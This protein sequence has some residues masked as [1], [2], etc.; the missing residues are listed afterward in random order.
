M[1]LLFKDLFNKDEITSYFK[2]IIELPT[3]K[4][5][6]PQ[7]LVLFLKKYFNFSDRE[8]LALNYDKF[9]KTLIDK[10]KSMDQLLTLTRLTNNDEDEFKYDLIKFFDQL[11]NEQIFKPQ[12]SGLKNLNST[13]F[14]FRNII[15]G[16]LVDDFQPVQ[17]QQ[18][19]INPE[20]YKEI[21]EIFLVNFDNFCQRY[22]FLL[23]LS[24]PSHV[25]DKEAYNFLVQDFNKFISIKQK[26]VPGF[27]LEKNLNDNN[28][29]LIGRSYENIFKQQLEYFKDNL[30]N[31]VFKSL[32]LF[33]EQFKNLNLTSS[34]ILLKGINYSNQNKQLSNWT[35]DNYILSSAIPNNIS[36]INNDNL[37]DYQKIKK[38]IVKNN[39]LS[40]YASIERYL[41]DLKI[42]KDSLALS[43]GYAILENSTS[44]FAQLKV[45]FNIDRNLFKHN[46]N[47]LLPL[48]TA[49]FKNPKT[50]SIFSHKFFQDINNYFKD[51]EDRYGA[52]TD[53]VEIKL[54]RLEIEFY[55]F[56]ITKVGK[57]VYGAMK[58]NLNQSYCLIR[59]IMNYLIK[60]KP[61]TSF[62]KNLNPY[63]YK[64]VHTFLLKFDSEIQSK[65]IMGD[66]TV[67]PDIENHYKRNINYINCNLATSI[68]QTLFQ[69]M[70]DSQYY[71]LFI[72]A[73]AYLYYGKFK[74]R[75][76]QLSKNFDIKQT[77]PQIIYIAWDIE[78]YASSNYLYGNQQPYCLCSYSS[79]EY[80]N[81]NLWGTNCIKEFIESIFNFT[82]NNNMKNI[83]LVFW[84]HNGSKF[85]NQFIFPYLLE[86]FGEDLELIG[87]INDKKQIRIKQ[88][89]IVFNDFCCFFQNSLDNICNNFQLP[90]KLKIDLNIITQENYEDNKSKIIEYC[91]NDAYILYLCVEKFVEVIKKLNI[92]NF[93]YSF[94]KIAT[95]SS[96]ALFILKNYLA[97][98]DQKIYGSMN[99][100]YEIEKSSYHGGYTLLFKKFCDYGYIYDI[101]SSY[102]YSL[103]LE[104]PYERDV[105]FVFDP[106][107]YIFSEFDL[108]QITFSS[109][110]NQYFSIFPIKTDDGSL[111]YVKSSDKPHWFWGIEIKFAFDS[112]YEIKFH[113]VLRYKPKAFLKNF[114]NSFY[115]LRLDEKNKQQPNKVL[116]ETYKL[117]LNSIYGKMGQ[118][119]FPISTIIH[120]SKIH[121]NFIHNV[122]SVETLNS[123]YYL[124]KQTNLLKEFDWI[125]SLVRIASF[126]TARS[127]VNLFKPLIEGAITTQNIFYCDTDSL[128]L[129]CQLPDR[130]LSQTELG[131]FKLETKFNQFYAV[132]P[133]LYTYLKYP[134]FTEVCKIKSAKQY[135]DNKQQ[136]NHE[137][138][139]KLSQNFGSNILILNRQFIRTPDSNILIKLIQKNITNSFSKRIHDRNS[140][141]TYLHNSIQSYLIYKNELDA[142]LED[143]INYKETNSDLEFQSLDRY[144][145]KKEIV[146]TTNDLKFDIFDLIKY[147]LQYNDVPDISI[148]HPCYKYR[149]LLL[150]LK[151]LNIKDPQP[152]TIFNYLTSDIM[153]KRDLIEVLEQ[154]NNNTLILLSNDL[155]WF[156][157]LFKNKILY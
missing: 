136:F 61:T 95:A 134:D 12:L 16:Y 63:K 49:Y 102:P 129:N 4:N 51:S 107:N 112:K 101:N 25:K 45:E 31:I 62:E 56:D 149:I 15:F 87:N 41:K 108:C 117:I 79:F 57:Y 130:Y 85:D 111:I 146:I 91:Q 66:I 151:F 52:D 55:K 11:E 73:H 54:V 2:R 121:K 34:Q 123:D 153:Q 139:K 7:K 150:N 32:K 126:V 70:K 155:L 157:D 88:Y 148:D 64:D 119:R 84:A 33:T 156:N 105:D 103:S 94:Q 18:S 6:Q 97:E 22:Y 19:Q 37:I 40:N 86:L 131:K 115:N 142:E 46:F 5:K 128:F 147:Y 14:D 140:E 27:K 89:N 42:L 110:T 75:P 8:I 21:R 67:I 81:L 118:R 80:F 43:F 83:K 113:N 69:Q 53:I 100:I 141:D 144:Y 145:N 106:T 28:F 143:Q 3:I 114:I 135:L 137:A 93:D 109:T 82:Q 44:N 122:I 96:F 124:V 74:I 72:N 132:A 50:W 60:T 116:A 1:S 65:L 152:S 104:L 13:L 78:T 138:I 20:N 99:D 68:T 17:L 10:N 58:N 77:E 90:T 30:E 59:A 92:P 71:I 9:K 35:I 26:L 29:N 76:Y 38:I 36:L 154:I 39:F 127:R 48:E 47:L 133:K 23:D 98:T 120:K 24:N 125:G